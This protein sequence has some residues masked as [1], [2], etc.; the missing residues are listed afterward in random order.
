APGARLPRPP[1]P[2]HRPRARARL[3]PAGHRRRVRRPARRPAPPRR[4]LPGL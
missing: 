3:P 1:H 4:Q 2:A